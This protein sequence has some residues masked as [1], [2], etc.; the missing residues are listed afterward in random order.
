MSTG[1]IGSA[2]G[3]IS[4]E[5]WQGALW[6]QL[7]DTGDDRH[8]LIAQQEM[9]RRLNSDPSAVQQLPERISL[10]ALPALSPAYL[11][12]LRAVSKH[13]D[14]TIYHQNFSRGYWA[15]IISEKERARLIA[16]AGE[17]A[18]QYFETGNSLLATMGR[19][20]RE[21][22]AG[23][24]QLEALETEVFRSPPSNT[25]LGQIQSDI[26]EL[27]ER[28]DSQPFEL[29]PDDDSLQLH[30]CPQHHAGDR[31]ST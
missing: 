5:N 16:D 28:D 26:F 4:A 19:Q 2:T 25:V 8:W 24:L 29:K 27:R 15:E 20:G 7:I 14:V 17:A 18:D 6:R 22:L 23:L 21:Q 30:C 10:F 1:P 13:I 3:S 12:F 31:G 11:E 9:L